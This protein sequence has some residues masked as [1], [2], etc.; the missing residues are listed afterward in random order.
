MKQLIHKDTKKNRATIAKLLAGSNVQVA[1]PPARQM[2]GG[3]ALMLGND[4]M[5]RG[6]NREALAIGRTLAETFPTVNDCQ[7]LKLN[8]LIR[9]EYRVEANQLAAELRNAAPANLGT[10]QTSAQLFM[11]L[12]QSDDAIRCLKKALTVAPGNI[13]LLQI[14]GECYAQQG[15]NLKAERIF[16][17]VIKTGLRKDNTAIVEEAMFQL[18]SLRGLDEQQEKAAESILL[19]KNAGRP[20]FTLAFALARG[21]RKVKDIDNEVH[22]LNIA[23]Q[24]MRAFESSQGKTWNR[25]LVERRSE[26]LKTLFPMP[27]PGWVEAFRAQP[28]ARPVYI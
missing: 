22:W 23:N 27:K 20:P 1:D 8:A 28:A 2:S 15:N 16:N 17:E 13:D 9:L 10:L 4:Y 12:N 11:L 14:L 3:D 19:R 6:R 7:L 18:A 24:E 25:E 26:M 5:L 21:A